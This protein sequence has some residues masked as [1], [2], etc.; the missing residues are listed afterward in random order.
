[1]VPRPTL[2][3]G[4]K[5]P[6]FLLFVRV[7]RVAMMRR[8]KHGNDGECV[9]A[10]IGVKASLCPVKH[11]SLVARMKP[12]MPTV[13]AWSCCIMVGIRYMCLLVAMFYTEMDLRS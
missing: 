3:R 8:R 12:N 11:A 9:K 5:S 1:M 6:N 7:A 2:R 13:H 10:S 4:R